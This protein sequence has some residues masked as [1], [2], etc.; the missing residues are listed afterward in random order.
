MNYSYRVDKIFN[1]FY[2]HRTLRTIFDTDASEWGNTTIE[3]KVEILEKILSSGYPLDKWIK[4][5]I[6]F[7]ITLK[8][9]YVKDSVSKALEILKKHCSS[10]LALD[11]MNEWLNTG[12][13][14]SEDTY[15]A[16]ICIQKLAFTKELGSEFF[17]SSLPLCVIDSVFSI[18]VKYEGVQNV[19]KRVGT[20]FSIPIF[21]ENGSEFPDKDL[22]FS[23]SQLLSQLDIYTEDNLAKEVFGNSQKT[24]TNNGILKASA[25][26]Q[27]LKILQNYK[28]EYFQDL[29]NVA[30]NET[31]EK[32]VK[33]IKGQSSGISLKYFYMLAGN[34]NLIKPDRMIKRFLLRETGLSLKDDEA[35]SLLLNTAKVISSKLGKS[36][37][38]VLLD[39]LIWQ[40]ERSL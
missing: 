24:S 8:K 17:Y 10:A 39:N 38:A 30:G 20:R 13:S 32:E 31:F 7:Y 27:F 2:Q 35:Q 15:L 21:R 26:V 3:K 36:V 1:R 23:T 6:D 12:K 11:Q 18:G 33:N 37:S 25:V 9:E 4:E 28:I 22:Q 16:D 29:I 19:M 40:Y 34:E 14:G 5:Y